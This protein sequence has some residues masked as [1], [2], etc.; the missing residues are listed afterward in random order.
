MQE[1][2]KFYGI[3]W[4]NNQPK[5]FIVD[6]R[7]D[8]NTIRREKTPDWL[9]GW[10]AG[11]A[12][13]LLNKKTFD[14][15]SDHKYTELRYFRLLKHELSHLF[16]QML[17][18]SSN[19]KWVNEGICLYLSGQINS[20]EPPVEFKE[21]LEF[22]DKAGES[23]YKEAGFAVKLLVDEFGKDKFIEFLK[24]L[25]EVETRESLAKVFKETFGKELSYETFNKLL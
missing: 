22:F 9:V 25:K 13:Y 12:V 18:N 2:R 4:V 11:R 16:Y 23:I 5:V 8:I 21:F 20:K 14:K 17:T 1:L 10:A 7:E 6:L 24:S 3:N 19:P 15:E